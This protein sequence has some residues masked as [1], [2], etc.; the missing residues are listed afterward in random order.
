MLEPAAPRIS[1]YRWFVGFNVLMVLFIFAEPTITRVFKGAWQRGRFVFENTISL[2][3]HALF[4]Y[5]FVLFF[6]GQTALGF[7]LPRRARLAPIHRN[8]GRAFVFAAAPLFIIVGVWM[9]ID[10]G[11]G[12]PPESTVVFRKHAVALIIELAQV[13]ALVTVY[14]AR[15]WLAIRRR[16]LTAHVD[17]MMTAFIAAAMIAGI[18]LVYAVIWMFGDS[19][20]SVSGVYFITVAATALELT[21]AYAM[22]GRLRK[23]AWSLALL[24]GSTALVAAAASPWYSIWDH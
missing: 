17:A 16:D 3:I 8:L 4:G 6:V 1:V 12:L 11:L 9:I 18:R 14:L 19:P 5:A 21:A 15:G 23:N 24:V 7:R 10:R 20:F 2:D 13:L 22:V